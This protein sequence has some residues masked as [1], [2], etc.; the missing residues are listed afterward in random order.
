MFEKMKTHPFGYLRLAFVVALFLCGARASAQGGAPVCFDTIYG[1]GKMLFARGEQYRQ[2]MQLAEAERY[3]NTAFDRFIAALGCLDKPEN[4]DLAEWISKTKRARELQLESALSQAE[5]SAEVAKKAL[6]SLGKVQARN[7]KIVAASFFYADRFALAFDGARYGYIDREG[8]PSIPFQYEFAAPFDAGTGFARVTRNGTLFLLDTLCSAYRLAEAIDQID[9]QTQ[10]VD[11]RGKNLA[12][13]PDELFRCKDAL[14]ILFLDNNRL[15]RL[16]AET[17]SMRQLRWLDLRNNPLTGLPDTLRHLPRLKHLEPA[18]IPFA[19]HAQTKPDTSGITS[20]PAQIMVYEDNPET[21][22]SRI[23]QSKKGSA[24]V[25][26]NSRLRVEFDGQRLFERITA[27]NESLRTVE[28][29]RDLNAPTLEAFA[30]QDA[31]LAVI[32]S[33]LN[34]PQTAADLALWL[35]AFVR[36]MRRD[37]VLR[38]Y[39]NSLNRTF[40]DSL[41]ASGQTIDRSAFILNSLLRDFKLIAQDRLELLQSAG[42]EIRGTAFLQQSGMPQLFL[43]ITDINGLPQPSVRICLLPELDK[44]MLAGYEQRVAQIGAKAARLQTVLQARLSASGQTGMSEP[45][46]ALPRYLEALVQQ[47]G[48]YTRPLYAENPEPRFFLDLKSVVNRKRLD[49]LFLFITVRKDSLGL[50]QAGERRVIL[51]KL[52]PHFVNKAIIGMVN[53]YSLD[54][55]DRPTFRFAPSLGALL[56]IDSRSSYFYNNHLT[57]GLGVGYVFPDADLDGKTEFGAGIIGTLFRDFISFGWGWNFTI[58]QPY[59][60][61]GLT[62]PTDPNN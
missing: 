46:G 25:D 8:N 18:G 35:P 51:T 29:F 48:E 2:R 54:S 42:V 14:Q 44:A 26:I 24:Y 19:K 62:Y 57:P 33:L 22:K 52:A 15:T 12:Y 56:K 39:F 36:Q 58:G 10:A 61:L 45:A 3:Y 16:P 1:E 7:E 6:D 30:R 49:E 17:G 53:P 47:A 41:L 38:G 13:F 50:V 27:V 31:V 20:L 55:P 9:E 28:R 32:D 43:P 4:N 40:N 37:T 59:F 34:Q 11:L 5:H 60:F 23:I 21:M